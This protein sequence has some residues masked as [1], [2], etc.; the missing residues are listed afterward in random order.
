MA[1]TPDLDLPDRLRSYQRDV[2]HERIR[3]HPDQAADLHRDLGMAA[4][5]IEH[6]R[7]ELAASRAK[8]SELRGDQ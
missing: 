6:G 8:R 7:R 5:D 1:E 3:C 2:R 4:A